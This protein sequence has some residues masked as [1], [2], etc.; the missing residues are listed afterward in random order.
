MMQR[1]RNV[2]WPLLNDIEQNKYYLKDTLLAI[3][4]IGGIWYGHS[5]IV[6]SSKRSRA[7]KQAQIKKDELLNKKHVCFDKYSEII[8]P[9]IERKILLMSATEIRENIIANKISCI[10]SVLVICYNT[11]KCNKKLNAILEEHYDSAY[12]EAIELDKLINKK[13]NNKEEWIKFIESKQLLGIPI[14]IKDLFVMKDSD[15]T[16]GLK[17]LCNKPYKYDGTIIK[18]IRDSGGI[19]Y[20]KSNCPQLNMLPG[21]I[22]IYVYGVSILIITFIL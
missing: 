17:R 14:S 9:E 13:R 16:I 15:C 12:N 18:L 20:V 21:I 19:P 22:S 3:A 1:L 6:T 10:E 2:A 5:K 8:K 7:S 11:Y 4:I